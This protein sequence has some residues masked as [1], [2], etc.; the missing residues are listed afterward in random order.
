MTTQAIREN[1]LK[2]SRIKLITSQDGNFV[3]LAHLL[4]V[5]DVF[6][7]SI[8]TACT[9]G[10]SVRWNP[11][12]ID[13]LPDNELHGILLHE[14]MHIGLL[15]NVVAKFYPDHDRLNIAADLAVNSILDSI[16][17]E[18][19]AYVLR[20][21]EGE[22]INLP[23]GKSLEF[24][25]AELSKKS[26]DELPEP[27]AGEIEPAGSEAAKGT[28]PGSVP[29]I[30]QGMSEEIIKAMVGEAAKKSE[31]CGNFSGGLASAVKAGLEEKVDYRSVLKRYRRK[32]CRGGVDWTRPNRRL[33]AAGVNLA[34]NKTRKVGDV[35]VLWDCSGSMPEQ[36]GHQC[37]AE[38]LAIFD[39]SVG[40]VHVWQHDIRVVHKDELK[41]GQELPNIER[42][43]HGGTS[44]VEPFLNIEESG[45]KPSLIICLSDCQ[46]AYP[47]TGPNVPVLWISDRPV[48][49]KPP[50]G[51]LLDI[52]I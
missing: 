42:K 31:G 20:A 21:G 45:L 44:H 13:T 26:D 39:E 8:K 12:F 47:V 51:D 28:A 27:G 49:S 1:R 14:L 15:H 9:D 43:T 6:D 22:F 33:R 34:R 30:G 7:P 37:L 38:I 50:F 46:T 40:T 41:H 24:Y 11:E 23:P 19:P 16:G 35:I 18:L 32:L 48:Y 5:Q 52:I 2:K 29:E 4:D 36:T 10:S 3:F 25:Y 17:A